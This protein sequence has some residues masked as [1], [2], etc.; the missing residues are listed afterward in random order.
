MKVG[1]ITIGQAPRI[2]VTCD[3]F[4]LLPSSVELIE[5]GG[6]DGMTKDEIEK[7]YPQEDDYVL[8]SK[9]NDGSSVKFAEKHILPMLQKIIDTMEQDGCQLIVFFCT[10][11]FPDELKSK[12]VPLLYPCDVLNKVVPLLCKEEGVICVTPDETQLTQVVT[13]WE[14][15]VPKVQSI[16]AS[17]YGDWQ[18]LEAAAEKIKT[19]KGDVVVLDC[20]GYTKK[21]KDMFAKK[22]GK[23]VV[24]PRTLLA[25]VI[26]EVADI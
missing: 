3:I 12:K 24:L 13:K 15:F 10:G 17:P 4:D 23:T 9:L 6:L 14:D 20:I 1:A 18:T 21:M 8:V 7:F 2:D 11:S 16:A 5:A 19:M 26:A 25:R 22:T